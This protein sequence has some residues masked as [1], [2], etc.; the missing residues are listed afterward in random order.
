MVQ[1]MVGVESSFLDGL[2]IE[3]LENE[4]GSC[5]LCRTRVALWTCSECGTSAWVI[6]CSHRRGSSWL[7][8]GRHDGTERS[9]IFCGDCADV[10]PA[11]AAS[12]TAA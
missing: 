5:P 4:G 6:E 7:R 2:E 11:T 8:R 9:R 1:G 10:L 12:A 3:E